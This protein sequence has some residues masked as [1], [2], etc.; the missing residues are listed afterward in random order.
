MINNKANP[1]DNINIAADSEIDPEWLA[2]WFW[3]P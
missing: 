1:H 3:L 2:K